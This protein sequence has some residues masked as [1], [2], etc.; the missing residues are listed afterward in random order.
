MDIWNIT[1]EER[2]PNFLFTDSYQEASIEFKN[3]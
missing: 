2:I 3:M 1:K